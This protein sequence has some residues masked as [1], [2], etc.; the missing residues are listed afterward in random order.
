MKY[1]DSS[2]YNCE[3]RER[4]ST[5]ISSLLP[6]IQWLHVYAL[7]TGVTIGYVLILFIDVVILF[8]QLQLNTIRIRFKND[9]DRF[10][11]FFLIY[12][13]ISLLLIIA[14]NYALRPISILNRFVKLILLYGLIASCDNNFIDWDSYIKSLK[15]LTYFACFVLLFQFAMISVTG[16]YYSIPIPY[17]KFANEST[18]ERI[19][20][21]TAGARAR[22]IF[23]EPA[24]FVFFVTQYLIIQLFSKPKGNNNNNLI[25]ALFISLCILLSTSSTGLFVLVFVWGIF[26]I[27]MW[28]RG[29]ISTQNLLIT[30]ITITAIFAGVYALLNNEHLNLSLY[31]LSGSYEKSNIVWK[32]IDANFDDVKDM[33]GI[34]RWIGYG[35]GNIDS[36]FMNSYIYGLL[37]FGIIGVGIAFLWFIKLFFTTYGIG[38]IS[39]II[40]IIL[41]SIDMV[42][43]TPTALGYF[44]I[45]QHYLKD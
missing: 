7:F 28:R 17:L 22:S 25:E 10:L 8:K 37:N 4:F 23:T 14:T 30:I 29:K 43:F 32:R 40:L 27:N 1:N 31:R 36:E 26:L 21:F 6:W 38:R 33:N 35:I 11:L 44:I 42:F 9:I 5:S 20:G 3:S 12:L 13:L 41:G 19:T 16:G 15:L 2:R 18:A 45:V 24:H 34:F 39:I